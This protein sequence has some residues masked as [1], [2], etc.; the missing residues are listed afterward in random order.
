MA[1]AAATTAIAQVAEI[2]VSSS[3]CLVVVAM[4]SWL[5][6]VA[7]VSSWSPI[8]SVEQVLLGIN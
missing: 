7:M 1:S 3:S 6:V 8:S 4:V 2:E 5:V